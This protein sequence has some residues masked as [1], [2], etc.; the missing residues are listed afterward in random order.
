MLLVCFGSFIV[1]VLFLDNGIVLL[2]NWWVVFFLIILINFF[3]IVLRVEGFSLVLIGL[4]VLVLVL[5]VNKWGCIR[6]LLL[7][8]VFI[9]I[10]DFKGVINIKFWFIFI[11]IILVIC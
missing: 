8:I 4:V 10:E 5:E 9:I 11:V 1:L 2:F 6:Y 3:C 7:A